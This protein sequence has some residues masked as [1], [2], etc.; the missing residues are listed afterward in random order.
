MHLQRTTRS[1]LS[2]LAVAMAVALGLL[3]GTPSGIASAASGSLTVLKGDWQL[4]DVDHHRGTFYSTNTL[5]ESQW[6]KGMWTSTDG[7]AWRKFGTTE[8]RITRTS[9]GLVTVVGDDVVLLDGPSMQPLAAREFPGY[10]RAGIQVHGVG[11]A[12]RRLWVGATEHF[13][14]DHGTTRAVVFNQPL[15]DGDD[16]WTVTKLPRRRGMSYAVGAHLL[17]RGQGVLALVS[18]EGTSGDATASAFEIRPSGAYRRLQ[19]PPTPAVRDVADAARPWVLGARRLGSFKYGGEI[20]LHRP[21]SDGGWATRTVA[22][23][24]QRQVRAGRR[25]P[26]ANAL[27]LTGRRV[28]VGGSELL[29]RC[30]SGT[31]WSCTQRRRVPVVWAQRADGS[32]AKIQLRTGARDGGQVGGVTVR[33]GVLWAVGAVWN[34]QDGGWSTNVRAASWRVA[35]P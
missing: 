27:A 24:T 12:D 8:G 25:V 4:S 32:F 15:D 5:S 21:T 26:E 17:Q 16:A 18:E 30:S 3:V 7:R 9:S 29:H 34:S 2:A 23:T 1:R 33:N 35:L 6:G 11:L 28:I 19:A 13:Q 31:Y 10:G 20:T 14:N 22:R